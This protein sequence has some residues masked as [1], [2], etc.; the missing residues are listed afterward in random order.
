[1]LQDDHRAQ[2]I[3]RRDLLQYSVVGLSA[4]LLTACATTAAPSGTPFS[5]MTWNVENLF[6]S[7]HRIGSQKVITQG[8]YQ[9][10]LAYLSARRGCA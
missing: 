5:V 1:M 7:G 10:K 3:S 4:A 2:Q 8:A 9:A 6:P